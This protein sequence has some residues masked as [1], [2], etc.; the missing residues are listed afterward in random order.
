M[1]VWVGQNH[2]EI[3]YGEEAEVEGKDQESE[4]QQEGC[5]GEKEEKVL[6]KEEQREEVGRKEVGPEEG[7]GQEGSAPEKSRT[8]ARGSGSCTCRSGASSIMVAFRVGHG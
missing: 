3:D 7:E 5:P 6:G 1:S 8:E 2:R 4:K